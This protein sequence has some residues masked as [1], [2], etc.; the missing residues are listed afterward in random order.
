MIDAHVQVR[1]K[2]STDTV[3][4]GLLFEI[5]VPA[6]FSGRLIMGRDG[7]AVGNALKGFFKDKFGKEKRVQFDHA[8]FEERYEV[9]ARD[10]D[11]AYR[12]MNR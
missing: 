4:D 5:D 2:R 3:F 1:R 6:N 9:Y 7:G 11:E 12:L 10:P 8:A